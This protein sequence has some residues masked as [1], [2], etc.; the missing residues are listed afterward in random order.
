MS[1]SNR[2]RKNKFVTRWIVALWLFT[3]GA[4]IAA[5][6][7]ASAAEQGKRMVRVAAAADL[8]LPLEE[9]GREFE[10]KSGIVV[11]PSFGASGTLFSQIVNGAPFDVFMSADADYPRKL[12][13]AGQA[14]ANTIRP[15]A[16]GT[17]VLWMSRAWQEGHGSNKQADNL[18][19]LL[20][21]MVTRISIANPLHAPYGKA[22][23]AALRSAGILDR[24]RPKLVT[25]ENVA[26][27]AQFVDS[28]NV[29]AGLVA[30]TAVVSKKDATKWLEVPRDLYPPIEQ[31]AIVTR[32]GQNNP[33]ASQFVEFLGSEVAQKI[34]RRYGFSEVSKL[35][36][37]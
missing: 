23:E 8:K 12:A 2:I 19:V 17:L 22:A 26:Q 11:Q 24:I 32:G 27:A 29:E 10:K 1:F 6:G 37:P 25:A 15:Y 36:K 5:S 33:G 31:S 21:P 20:D 16:R 14:V 9:I 13:E 7:Q 30:L 18:Q 28:G 34:L 3:I 35:P 4:A